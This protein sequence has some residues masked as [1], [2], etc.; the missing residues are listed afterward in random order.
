MRCRTRVPGPRPWGRILSPPLAGARDR[1]RARTGTHKSVPAGPGPTRLVPTRARARSPV[2]HSQR[3][4]LG[5]ITSSPATNNSTVTTTTAQLYIQCAHLQAIPSLYK[6][7][8]P[9]S[10]AVYDLYYIFIGFSCTL[11]RFVGFS[12]V[13]NRCMP[14]NVVVK[15][16]GLGGLVFAAM[17]SCVV[18]CKR[19][20][21]MHLTAPLHNRPQCQYVYEIFLL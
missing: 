20:A 2:S 1:V 3:R 15:T 19:Y 10:F 13:C 17:Y 5:S 4:Y 7:L 9:T 16:S 6:K 14:T 11:N 21:Y 8:I 12:R 18:R